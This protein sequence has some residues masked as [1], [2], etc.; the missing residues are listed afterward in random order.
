[1]AEN[2]IG[3]ALDL[4]LASLGEGVVSLGVAAALPQIEAW[5]ERLAASGDPDL[6]AVAK[7]LEDLRNQL[8]SPDFDP[9][10]VGA[11]LMSLGDQV[12][13]VAGV[14]I[15]ERVGGKLS[16]LGALLGKEGDSLTDRMTRV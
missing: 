14:E 12:E 7:T 15:G 5:Q 11:L 9:V 6:E 13:Q 8:G 10:S 2:D 1:M 16:Q 3:G 4:T